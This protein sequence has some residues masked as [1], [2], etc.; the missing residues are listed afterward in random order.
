MAK[1]ASLPRRLLLLESALIR[2]EKSLRESVGWSS[3]LPTKPRDEIAR[4][5]NLVA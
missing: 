2:I 1:S 5:F 3:T 4:L